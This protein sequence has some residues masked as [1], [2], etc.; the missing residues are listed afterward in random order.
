MK[1]LDT[2]LL[3]VIT[4][5]DVVVCPGVQ[6]RGAGGGVHVCCRPAVVQGRDQ[7]GEGGVVT[8]SRTGALHLIV[9]VITGLVTIGYLILNTKSIM[10]REGVHNNQFLP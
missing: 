1:H 5:V 8:R 4:E 10:R 9:L 2:E 3:A 7:V 6:G